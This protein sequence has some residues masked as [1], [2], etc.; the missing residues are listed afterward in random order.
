MGN[1]KLPAILKS[2][3]SAKLTGD[4]ATIFK[5]KL[6]TGVQRLYLKFY[7]QN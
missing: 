5:L 1:S 4:I 6:R 3:L 7:V 2:M